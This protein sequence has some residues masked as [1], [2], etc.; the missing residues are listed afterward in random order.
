MMEDIAIP[1]P[2]AIAGLT[3]DLDSFA[4]N[5]TGNTKITRLIFVA[6]RSDAHRADAYKMAI[7]EIFKNTTNTA[8]YLEVIRKA[9]DEGMLCLCE[10]FALHCQ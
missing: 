7:D 9:N 4:A 2:A 8:L 5:Y 3:I 6:E 1:A 10:P